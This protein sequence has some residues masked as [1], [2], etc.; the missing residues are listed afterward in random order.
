MFSATEGAVHLANARLRDENYNRRKIFFGRRYE[1][2]GALFPSGPSA[3]LARSCCVNQAL[4]SFQSRKTL[5]G[6]ILRTSEISSTL[7]P[8]KKRISTT[9]ALRGSRLAS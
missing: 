8:P 5:D 7:S 4:A 9:C 1:R 2:A 3:S 6:E